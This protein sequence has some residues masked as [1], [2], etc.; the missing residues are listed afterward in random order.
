MRSEIDWLAIVQLP[1]FR[2]FNLQSIHW[3]PNW[4]R[5]S[6]ACCLSTSA[7]HTLAMLTAAANL[8]LPPLTVTITFSFTS[9]PSGNYYWYDSFGAPDCHQC[10]RLAKLGPW[11]TSLARRGFIHTSTAFSSWACVGWDS[12]SAAHGGVSRFPRTTLA[13]RVRHLLEQRGVCLRSAL[14]PAPELARFLELVRI[15]EKGMRKI[16]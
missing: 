9:T 1:F 10:A 14:L 7:A 13:V 3:K 6:S 12:P 11:T 8:R 16:D 15:L 5:P 4:R 2:S